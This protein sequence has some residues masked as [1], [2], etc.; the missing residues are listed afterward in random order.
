[1]SCENQKQ[2]FSN[3]HFVQ[4]FATYF[5]E[6]VFFGATSIEAHMTLWSTL[7]ACKSDEIYK[8]ISLNVD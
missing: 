3:L 7:S 5:E 8:W 1:M 2:C 4:T 6:N